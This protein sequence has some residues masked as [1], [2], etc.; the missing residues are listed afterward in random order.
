MDQSGISRATLNNYI[1]LGILPKP[2]VR[3]PGGEGGGARQLGYFPD[4]AVEQ[5]RR[6]R[7]LKKQGMSMSEIAAKAA[8]GNQ[9]A[10]LVERR[11]D[12]QPATAGLDTSPEEASES[13]PSAEPGFIGSAAPVD[14]L[15]E[16]PAVRSAP[17]DLDRAPEVETPGPALASLGSAAESLSL[18]V[19]GLKHP[20]YM[21]NYNFE[22]VWFNQ[23]AVN[24]MPTIF[25][26]LPDTSDGR[27]IFRLLLRAAREA[28]D[29]TW[30]GLIDL[31]A[32]IAKPRLERQALARIY[33]Y[34]ASSEIRQ[35]ERSFEKGA[36]FQRGGVLQTQAELLTP[37]GDVKPYNLYVSYYREGILFSYVPLDEQQES[38]LEL[39]S[40]RDRVI[41]EL[42][43]RRLPVLTR[44]CVLV[45]D[46]QDS[47]KIC[48][49]LPPDEYFELINEIWSEMELIFRQYYGVHGKHVGDGMVYYFFP[50]PDC[51]YVLNAL[52]CSRQIKNKMR[53][54][55]QRWQ[56]RKN[57]PTELFLNTGLHEGE[58]WLGTFQATTSVEFTALGDTINHAAR[59][60]D[61]ASHGAI[62][63]TKR[64]IGKLESDERSLVRYGVYQVG[65]DARPVLVES[66]Y[67]RFSSLVDMEQDRHE[68]LRDIANLPVAEIIDIDPAEGFSN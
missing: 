64:L 6:V 45:A 38:L 67:A 59:L 28:S 11:R 48:A 66:S 21:V 42:L 19:E 55:S 68:K 40:N 33:P 26:E 51:N 37:A 31:H 58:E 16:K 22:V 61:F 39:L 43:K 12:E 5:I 1:A 54:I 9:S 62:W 15:V 24:R 20:A 14:D 46:L 18:T 8:Q 63:V 25:N 2:V 41:R 10:G 13:G 30:S 60:S 29:S 3:N 65:R 27:S 32:S 50:Q 52:R 53:E 47:V 44:L 17:A 23:S 49:E 4:S 56:A 34:L 35:L 7:V 57:W 36:L